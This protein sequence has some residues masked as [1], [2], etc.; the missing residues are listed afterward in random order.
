MGGHGWPYQG[1]TYDLWP[2]QLMMDFFSGGSSPSPSPPSP[3]PPGP[4]PPSPL[5]PSPSP[6]TPSGS[7]PKTCS[8]YTC[9]EWYAYNGNTCAYEEKNY[10]CDCSGCKCPG[11]VGPSPPGPSPP[12][13]PPPTPA[14]SCP[15]TCDGYTCD[16]WYAYNGNTCAYE[17]K[18]YGCDCSGCKCPGG[19]VVV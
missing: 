6:P 2:G 9:D 12:S 19:Q 5:P 14:G 11:D 10:G 15:K 3:S 4:S 7:C 17:E 13:P 8:G 18:N 1:Q 16:E